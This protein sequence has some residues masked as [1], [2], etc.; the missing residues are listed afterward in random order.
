MSRKQKAN[1]L[2]EKTL[3]NIAS[4]AAMATAEERAAV[5]EIIAQAKDGKKQM[6]IA[7]LTPAMAALLFTKANDWNREWH[8]ENSVELARRM[9]EGEW[10]WN[11]DSFGFYTT[12]NLSNGQ[13]RLGAA[14]LAGLALEVP[15]VFGIALVWRCCKV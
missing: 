3:A 5:E 15:I 4:V 1:A 6:I 9:T 12:G 11:G 13:H 8:P 2:R 7:K 14:V 10:A